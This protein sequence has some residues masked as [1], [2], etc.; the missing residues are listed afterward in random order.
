MISNKIEG[1][2]RIHKNSV[3]ECY[4]FSNVNAQ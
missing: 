1:A 4:H 3:Q 2:H